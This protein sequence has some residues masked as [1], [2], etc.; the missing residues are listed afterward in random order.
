MLGRPR[1]GA[2]IGS[3]VV[4]WRRFFCKEVDVRVRFAPSPTGE[5]HLGGV[6]TALFNFL[7]ARRHEGTFLLRIEDTDQS[8]TVPGA[9]ERI[10]SDLTWMGI[11]PD[12]G[13]EIYKQ[14]EHLPHYREHAEQLILQGHAYRCF[15][16][17]ERLDALR[18]SAKDKGKPSFYDRKCLHLSADQIR[19]NLDRALPHTI[20]MLVPREQ[21]V[22]VKD[23]VYES[24]KFE[25]SS[26]DDQILI[27][28]D[29]FPTYHLAS[30]VDDH[31]QRISHVI[32]GEEWMPSVPKHLLL[33]HFFKWRPPRFAHLPLLL[34]LDKSKL[35][36]RQEASSLQWY[37]DQGY[38]KEAILSY[39][40][41]L[42]WTPPRREEDEHNCLTLTDLKKTFSLDDI[43]K[44]G[45]VVDTKKLSSINSHFLNQLGMSDFQRLVDSAL[46]VIEEVVQ[47]P[48]RER[49]TDDYIHR[50]IQL[51]TVS[52]FGR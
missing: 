15:C 16:T 25:C 6:R 7:F 48:L 43:H 22:T 47:F 41:A 1:G 29:G 32:R 26:V 28:S 9:E 24:I 17:P 49:F 46:P 4:S 23:M 38:E 31:H 21:S 12:A 14:S 44:S 3:F 34:N 51:I 10:L 36:K 13:T 33:Y 35:S 39:I 52:D 8:R 5:L 11:P 42:G 2:G 45:A 18:K 19:D 27:K 50:V 20:R 37:R 30:V 40:A